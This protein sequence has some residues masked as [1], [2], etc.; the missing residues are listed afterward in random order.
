L[1]YSIDLDSSG[2]ILGNVTTKLSGGL[3]DNSFIQFYQL[4][5][6]GVLFYTSHMLWILLLSVVLLLAMCGPIILTHKP[7]T[8]PPYSLR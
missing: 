5:S 2:L 6:F 7:T 1:V 3:W 8:T 4:E